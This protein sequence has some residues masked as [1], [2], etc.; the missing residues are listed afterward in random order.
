M[1]I[2]RHKLLRIARDHAMWPVELNKLRCSCGF[3]FDDACWHDDVVLSDL[4]LAAPAHH[5]FVI[6]YPDDYQCVQVVRTHGAAWLNRRDL[7]WLLDQPNLPDEFR[8]AAAV[9]LP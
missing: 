9:H 1:S 4:R 2:P 6:S 5:T 3:E 7:A 8:R